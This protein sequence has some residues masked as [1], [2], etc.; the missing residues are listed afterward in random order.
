MSHDPLL[1]LSTSG[2]WVWLHCQTCLFRNGH[3]REIITPAS[4]VLPSCTVCSNS[5]KLGYLEVASLVYIWTFMPIGR[6]TVYFPQACLYWIS[7]ALKIKAKHYSEPGVGFIRSLPL[8]TQP[9]VIPQ[10][11]LF[12]NICVGTACSNKWSRHVGCLRDFRNPRW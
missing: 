10:L 3:K 8:P 1:L 2:F 5:Y 6:S 9:E 12:S 11:A 7:E 4:L